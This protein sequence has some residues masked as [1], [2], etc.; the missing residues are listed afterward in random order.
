MKPNMGTADR[1][2][3]ILVAAVIAILYFTGTVSG[4]LGIVL[5]VLAGVFVATSVVSFCPLYAPFGMSTCP[6]K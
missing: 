6:K 5:L 3:R 2:V 4:T 1:I